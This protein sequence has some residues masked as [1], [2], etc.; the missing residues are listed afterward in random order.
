MIPMTKWRASLA[1][2]AFST[3]VSPLPAAAADLGGYE[4]PGTS[5]YAPSERRPLDNSY[6]DGYGPKNWTGLYLGGHGGWGAGQSAVSGAIDSNIDTSGFFGGVHGGYNYQSGAFVAGLELDGDRLGVDGSSQLPGGNRLD[7]SADWLSSLRMRLGYAT[8]NLLLYGTAGVALGGLDASLT[9]PGT[10]STLSNTLTGYA[11]GLGAEMALTQSISAR[12]EG[13]H[14]GFGSE[15]FATPRG[16]IDA[17]LDLTTIR[18]GLSI[19]L[20]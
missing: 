5:Y 1:A 2:F 19:K 6:R 9:G 12:I 7:V 14:Y 20:N 4:A 11:A 18:A 10:D 15:T 16:P 13:L 3:L 17:D 8:G